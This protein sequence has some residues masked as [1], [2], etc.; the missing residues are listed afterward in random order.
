MSDPKRNFK[1]QIQTPAGDWFYVKERK[2][3]FTYS[4]IP[5]D[6]LNQD[7]LERLSKA[8]PQSKF[9]VVTK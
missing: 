1:L 5:T 8:Y 4:I 9:R 7:H 3:G 2:E 6:A